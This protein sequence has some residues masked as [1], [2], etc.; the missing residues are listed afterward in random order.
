MQEKKLYFHKLLI[1][2]VH[3]VKRITACYTVI[4]SDMLLSGTQ[5]TRTDP[6]GKKGTPYHRLNGHTG[7][8][9]SA[10]ESGN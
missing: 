7:L 5:R 1:L 2:F 3:T 9:Q 4:R 8:R 6:D 10:A